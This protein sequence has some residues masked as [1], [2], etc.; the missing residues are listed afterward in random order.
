LFKPAHVFHDD[1][2]FVN[3]QNISLYNFTCRL[4]QFSI[5]CFVEVFS[6]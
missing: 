1:D 2:H 5:C 3:T 4:E 6:D